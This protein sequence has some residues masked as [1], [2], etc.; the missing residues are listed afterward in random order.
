MQTNNGSVWAIE[1]PQLW[2][3]PAPVISYGSWQT[4]FVGEGGNETQKRSSQKQQR[5]NPFATNGPPF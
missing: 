3:S 2:V 5:E 1:N 4:F